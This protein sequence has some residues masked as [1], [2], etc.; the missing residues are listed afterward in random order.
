MLDGSYGYRLQ[1]DATDDNTLKR[2]SQVKI[3]LNGVDPHQG[4]RSRT[5]QRSAD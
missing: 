1:F 2:Y 5:L 4:G 3:S